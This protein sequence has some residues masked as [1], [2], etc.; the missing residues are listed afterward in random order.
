[1][2]E[3]GWQEPLER[4][5]KGTFRKTPALEEA[6]TQLAQNLLETVLVSQL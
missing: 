4:A 5:F 1:M 3:M 2:R 6:C